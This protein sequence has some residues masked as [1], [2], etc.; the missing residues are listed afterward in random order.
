MSRRVQYEMPTALR[1]AQQRFEEW[2]DSQSGRRAIPEPLW[3]LATEMGRQQG[4]FRTAQALRLDS[5]KLMKRVRASAPENKSGAQ[6][7]PSPAAAFV[8]LMAP[9]T[10]HAC[11]CLIE[12]EG[13]RGRMRIEWKGATAPDLAGFSRVLWEPG[14]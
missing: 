6:P 5:T 2:R 1:E 12:I 9:P 7:Q 8:E 11:E 3:A 13:P 4:V 14:A 10:S